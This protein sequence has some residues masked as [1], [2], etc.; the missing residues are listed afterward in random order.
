MKPDRPLLALAA[1]LYPE[2]SPHPFDPDERHVGRCGLCNCAL[3]EAKE[4]ERRLTEGG[5]HLAPSQS[6]PESAPA[7]D[8]RTAASDIN[9]CHPRQYDAWVALGFFGP[10]TSEELADRYDSYP[11]AKLTPQSAASIRTRLKELERGG[12]VVKTSESRRTRNGGWAAVWVAS[13]SGAAA[14]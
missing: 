3:R 13:E 9:D 10:S 1:A 5:W 8:P 2:D 14:A 12:H 6:L 11:V 4:L 7:G